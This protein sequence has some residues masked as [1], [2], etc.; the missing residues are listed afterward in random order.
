MFGSGA[1]IRGWTRRGRQSIGYKKPVKREEPVRI[2]PAGRIMKKS[3]IS[4][5]NLQELV[6]RLNMSIL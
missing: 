3:L 2:T 5:I 1:L 6:Y 4:N